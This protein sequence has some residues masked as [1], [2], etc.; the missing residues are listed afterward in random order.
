[1]T[2]DSF[3]GLYKNSNGGTELM[4][5]ELKKRIDP[6]L[7]NEV[8]IICS[9]V[10]KLEEKPR[11]LWC[12][13]LW[14]D[15]EIQ[16]LRRKESRD[17]FAKIIMVSNF[18]MQTYNQGLQVPYHDCLVIKNCIEPINNIINTEK[19]DEIRLIYHTTPHRGLAI[20]LPVFDWIT[21]NTE[22]RVHLDVYS[23]FKIYGWESRDEEF[24]EL[25]KFC[26][27]HPN[28]TYHGTVSN[29]EIREALKKS[30]IFAFPSTWTETSCLAAM[31]AMSAGNI[32]VHPNL[33][34]L[35]ETTGGFGVEYQYSENPNQ[36]ANIFASVLMN[37]IAKFNV[38]EMMQK[39]ANAQQHIIHNYSWDVRM[40]AWETL[41]QT[42][43]TKNK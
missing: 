4:Y 13:D 23:S 22:F 3:T 1:M 32:I 20:L 15:S 26:K 28:I 16:H 9:R 8:Q 18:Q 41:F 30:H 40:L 17:R 19:Q 42:I 29:P 2:I 34:A 14:N 31:E 10:R 7:F 12:H 33:G 37:V 24:E 36:H 39:R 11:L 5:Q 27:T 35:P 25:F 43:L 6:D 38:P 21:K